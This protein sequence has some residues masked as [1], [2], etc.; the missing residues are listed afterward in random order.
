MSWDMLKGTTV[1]VSF[2][3]A[4][5]QLSRELDG[6]ATDV[7]LQ[8]FADC[9]FVLVTQLRKVGTLVTLLDD[10]ACPHSLTSP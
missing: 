2:I 5:R 3:M 10:S 1:A 7:V 4:T 8:T 6:R 9:I